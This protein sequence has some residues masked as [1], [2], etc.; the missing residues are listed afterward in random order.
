MTGIDA[1]W[2]EIALAAGAILIAM[3]VVMFL[4]TRRF[5]RRCLRTEGTVIG[6]TEEED[7]SGVYYLSVIGFVDSSG[8][9]HQLTGSFSREPPAQGV[10]V[11]ITY[12]PT[13][14]RNAWVTGK[15]APWILPWFVAILGVAALVVGIGMRYGWIE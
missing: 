5:V 13:Y 1:L 6:H 10:V 7:D 9:S 8:A 15:P 4:Q 3:A 12:D 11:P 14:P 2:D